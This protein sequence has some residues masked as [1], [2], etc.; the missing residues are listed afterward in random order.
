M[1]NLYLPALPHCHIPHI[2][3]FS[4]LEILAKM[5]LGRCVNFSLSAI[6]AI[7]RTL[8]VAVTN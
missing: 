8:K 3:N 2:G 6:S 7:S 4:R 5:M 1:K